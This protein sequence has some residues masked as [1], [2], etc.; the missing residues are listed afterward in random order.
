M[1]NVA[2]FFWL[3]ITD[4]VSLLQRNTGLFNDFGGPSLAIPSKPFVLA[5]RM[6]IVA[7]MLF[8]TSYNTL[9]HVRSR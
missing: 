1:D 7:E 3:H 6:T 9:Q 4:I 2:D 8:R 5:E